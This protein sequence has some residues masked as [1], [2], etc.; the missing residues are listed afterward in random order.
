MK[1]RDYEKAFIEGYEEYIEIDKKFYEKLKIY[2]MIMVIEHCSWS[3]E[4]AREYYKEN[5]EF[6][7]GILKEN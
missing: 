4:K 7:K 5:I 3:Y 1:N 6:L 2:L